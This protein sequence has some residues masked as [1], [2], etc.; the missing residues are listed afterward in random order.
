MQHL[1]HKELDEVVGSRECW[2]ARSLDVMVV[3]TELDDIIAYQQ[4]PNESLSMCFGIWYFY[5]GLS[6]LEGEVR[7][8][9]LS[10]M[11]S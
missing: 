10:L 2:L 8:M 5:L 3:I 6:I 4:L 9:Q 11:T 7:R 1:N